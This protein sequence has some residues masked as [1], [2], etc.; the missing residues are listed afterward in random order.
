MVLAGVE[1]NLLRGLIELHD[2]VERQHAAELARQ[3][4]KKFPRIPVPANG[5]RDADQGAIAGAD[6]GRDHIRETIRDESHILL[7]DAAAAASDAL[8]YLSAHASA[9]GRRIAHIRGPESGT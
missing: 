7:L 6:R 2:G 1:V 5:L 8:K 9:Y 4:L 3:Q